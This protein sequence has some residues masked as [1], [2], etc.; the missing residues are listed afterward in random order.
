MLKLEQKMHESQAVQLAALLSPT[1]R[2]RP[3]QILKTRQADTA[4]LGLRP[5]PAM[6]NGVALEPDLL[7]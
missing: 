7:A 3:A 1:S 2:P 6:R 5:H 4:T